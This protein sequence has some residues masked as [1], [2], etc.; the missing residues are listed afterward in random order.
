MDIERHI[1]TMMRPYAGR[2]HSVVGFALRGQEVSFYS[3][4]NHPPEVLAEDQVFEIGSITKVFTALL[5]SVMAEEGAVDP[6]APLSDLS[7]Q[8]S[9]V[10]DWITPERLASHTAGFPNIYVPLWKALFHQRSDGPYADFSRHDLLHWLQE[11]RWSSQTSAQMHDRRPRHAYSNIG[12]GLLGE[13][14]AIKAGLSYADLLNEKVIKPLGLQDTAMAL[15]PDQH[16]R[17][18]APHLPNGRQVPPWSFQALAGAGGL[19]SSARDLSRLSKR[20]IGAL[21]VPANTLD[22]ALLRSA[23]PILGLGRRGAMLPSAQ[24]S[25]WLQMTMTD[26]AEPYLFHNGATAG[27]SCALYICPAKR[28]AV[29][30]LSN[31]G[32]AG[33]LLAGT[34][35]NLSNPYL[36]AAEFFAAV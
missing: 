13:A 34:R 10:P 30:I 24:C 20:V 2:Q 7:D 31:N 29:G 33:N 18:M 25:G 8:L 11:R 15:R 1:R 32:V 19:R 35:L 28:A 16:A 9:M 3:S 12:M 26:D 14:L 27:S 5:L 23:A 21:A 36:R 4:A 17:F 22:R 6:K